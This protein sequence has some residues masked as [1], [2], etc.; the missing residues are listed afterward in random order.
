MTV[1]SCFVFNKDKKHKVLFYPFIVTFIFVEY[2]RDKCVSVTAYVIKARETV[3]SFSLELNKK[4]IRLVI[5]KKPRSS[6]S[7]VLKIFPR[8]ET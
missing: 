8:Q 5:T 3:G 2:L 6:V 4:T 1:L 7:S